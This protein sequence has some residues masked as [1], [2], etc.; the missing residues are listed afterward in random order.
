MADMPWGQGSVRFLAHRMSTC[1]PA[2]FPVRAPVARHGT[3][4]RQSAHPINTIVR[5]VSGQMNEGVL[6][7]CPRTAKDLTLA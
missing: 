4:A 6:A 3:S 2:C 1:R 5:A 7:R